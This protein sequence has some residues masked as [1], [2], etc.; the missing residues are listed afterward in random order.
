MA[1]GQCSPSIEPTTPRS[2]GIPGTRSDV[3]RAKPGLSLSLILTDACC[4]PGVCWALAALGKAQPSSALEECPVWLGGLTHIWGWWLRGYSG[5]TKWGVLY[6]R[7]GGEGNQERLHEGGLELN[8]EA[9]GVYQ[10]GR[11]ISPRGAAWRKAWSV[12]YTDY[13]GQ[14]L[15]RKLCP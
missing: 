11:G 3:P 15:V 5:S 4:V 8:Q 13:A 14:C 7:G 10:S 1:V 9:R 2:L 12:K 6:V